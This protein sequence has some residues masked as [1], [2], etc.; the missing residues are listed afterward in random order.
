MPPSNLEAK[1]GE[2]LIFELKITNKRVTQKM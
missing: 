1:K 2:G